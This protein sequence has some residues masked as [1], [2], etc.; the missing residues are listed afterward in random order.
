MLTVYTCIKAYLLARY[1]HTNHTVIMPKKYVFG[2]HDGNL[3]FETG[4]F[5]TQGKGNKET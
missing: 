4:I 3:N 1:I 2:K 5:S